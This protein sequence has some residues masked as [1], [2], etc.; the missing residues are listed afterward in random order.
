[1]E[2]RAQRIRVKI[3]HSLSPC[4]PDRPRTTLSLPK[5]SE[6]EWKDPDA[7]SSHYAASGGSLE[8][9]LKQFRRYGV[10]QAFYA[11]V[12]RHKTSGFSHCGNTVQGRRAKALLAFVS[13]RPASPT[14]SHFVKANLITSAG[15]LWLTPASTRFSALIGDSFLAECDTACRRYKPRTSAWSPGIW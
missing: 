2:A 15:A 14:I 7:D 9:V 10:E 8:A 11:C 12:R 6:W 4:H 3:I 13:H 1:V 5:G